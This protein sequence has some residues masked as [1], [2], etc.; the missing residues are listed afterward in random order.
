MQ[1][2]DSNLEISLCN[3]KFVMVFAGV[4][5]KAC[6]GICQSYLRRFV[7]VFANVA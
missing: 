1:N 4:V 5:D 6:N 3:T 2:L 7:M